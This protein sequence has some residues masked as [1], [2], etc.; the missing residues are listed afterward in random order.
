MQVGDQAKIK[1][2]Q[3]HISR[4]KQSSGSITQYCRKVGISKDTFYCWRKK[5]SAAPIKAPHSLN[6]PKRSIFVPVQVEPSASQFGSST[7]DQLSDP[8][9]LG[10]FA[11]AF[12]RGLR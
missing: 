1:F 7:R 5:L 3:E 11:A 6:S 10:E 12:L 4:Q 8:R 2:W 9:W